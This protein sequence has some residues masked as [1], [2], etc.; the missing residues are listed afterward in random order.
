MGTRGGDMDPA[1]PV[2]LA[3]AGWNGDQLDD[4]LN[5]QCGLMGLTGSS[6]LRDVTDLAN[7][8]D[9]RAELARQVMAH[10]LRGYI[11]AYAAQ[12]GGLDV[13]VFTAG[14]GEH[15]PWL[16]AAACAGLSFLGITLSQ[17]RNMAVVG[18]ATPQVISEAQS[19]VRVVVVPTNEELAIA[20]Q[21]ASVLGL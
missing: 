13:L 12:L 19:Q 20:R 3:R 10:R 21:A 5:H 15:A 18:P 4:F 16:R 1:I 14:I 8:G 9:E 17:E 11:G 7:A 2:I 6:D